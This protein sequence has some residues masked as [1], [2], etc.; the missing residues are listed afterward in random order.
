MAQEKVAVVGLGYVGIPL[1]ALLASKGYE[2]MGVDVSE[3]RASSVGEGRLPLKGDE[4]GLTELL[5]K[6]V[7][8]GAL[9]ASSSAG[10]LGGR[11]VIFVCVDTPIDADRR[12]DHSSLRKALESVA[13]NMSRGTLV[14]VESTL[15]PGT[16]VGVVRPAL[17]R[18]SGLKAGKDFGLAHCPE[19]VMPGRLLK[20][21]TT[22]DRVIGGLDLRSQQRA[23]AIYSKLTK[24]KLHTTDLTTAEI[25]KTA[26]NAYR[27]V[28]IAFAN[29]VALISE[30]LGADAFEV[31]RLVN[32]CPFRDMHL[33][34]AGVGGHCLPK[35]PW[36]LAT[37]G[38]AANPKL[39]PIARA[40]NDSMP[41]HVL[42]LADSLLG[43]SGLK[44]EDA[45]VTVLGASFLQDSGDARNSPSL[46]VVESLKRAKE[47]R[48]HDPFLGDFAGLKVQKDLKKALAGADLA[49]F[50]V[51]H[52]E[53]LKLAPGA[54]KKMM[55]T[56]AVVDGRNIFEA[57]KMAKA[58]I[59]YRGV[60]K[61]SLQ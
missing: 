49:I 5:A 61:G 55:K 20:N 39:I 43:A 9:K 33:P 3:E 45:V 47:L 7:R 25:V 50:M 21:I 60:G 59:D 57:R 42:D 31:R 36:L 12:P 13:K 24:G 38:K 40:V 52:K 4:P 28:Q 29:E 44:V 41:F 6:G 34:G 32:T 54:L 35:D 58:G 37:A 26:E 51:S 53:Y 23:C 17:E 8:K 48:V 56:P 22:Y 16:M 10:M 11:K 1:A 19:R 46:P 2:V 14:I 15:A 18:G 27:D 30:K